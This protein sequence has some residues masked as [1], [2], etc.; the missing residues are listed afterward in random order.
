MQEEKI[1]GDDLVVQCKI[2][3][4]DEGNRF[5]RYTVGFGAGEASVSASIELFNQ[6]DE[7]RGSFDI[8]ASLKAGAFGGDA[9]GL[10]TDI[11]EGVVEKIKNEYITKEKKRWI[12]VRLALA[13]SQIKSML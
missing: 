7:S 9:S 1:Y 5:L 12:W 6:Q 4:Y 13:I 10:F 2:L 8:N 11:A 3:H